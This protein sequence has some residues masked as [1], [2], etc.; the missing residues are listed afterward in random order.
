MTFAQVGFQGAVV[1]ITELLEK[2]WDA[3]NEGTSETRTY[4]EGIKSVHT[5]ESEQ[6]CLIWKGF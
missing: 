2:P 1:K 3:I 4:L 5:E 6:G